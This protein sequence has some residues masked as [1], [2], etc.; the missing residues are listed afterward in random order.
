M[1]YDDHGYA[2][3]ISITT[4]TLENLQIQIKKLC[5]FS[6]YTGLELETSKCEAIGPLWGYRNSMSKANIN[7]LTNQINTIKFEDGTNIKYL[8]PDKSYK[9]LRVKIN[10][11][12]NFRDNYSNPNTVGGSLLTS[13]NSHNKRY[14]RADGH[15]TTII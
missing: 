11:V 13:I 5:L 4:E 12:L 8:P 10:P 3:G 15:V 6:K 1:T 9:I 2:D 7:L 14:E